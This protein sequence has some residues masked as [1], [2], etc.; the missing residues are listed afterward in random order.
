MGISHEQHSKNGGWP[1]ILT[2]TSRE[3]E[4]VITAL[5]WVEREQSLEG[6]AQFRG[7][8]KSGVAPS[9][10]GG[11]AVRKRHGPLYLVGGGGKEAHPPRSLR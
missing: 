1:Y 2:K 10:K 3:G 5:L 8:K 11:D 6:R 4:L 9:G 7:K